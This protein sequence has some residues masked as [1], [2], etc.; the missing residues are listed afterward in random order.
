[1]KKLMVFFL[2]S[3]LLIEPVLASEFVPSSPKL[4]K[5]ELLYEKYEYLDSKYDKI[6]YIKNVGFIVAKKI[7]DASGDFDYYYGLY[8]TN[9][10]KVVELNKGVFI[11][12]LAD[13]DYDYI[14]TIAFPFL[15]NRKRFQRF[16]VVEK[17][18]KYALYDGRTGELSE[19]VF[20]NIY[21]TFGRTPIVCINGKEYKL[22]PVKNAF[23]SSIYFVRDAGLSII[24]FPIFVG[25][26]ILFAIAMGVADM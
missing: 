8:D 1:M 13:K 6:D 9:L 5:K 16:L 15:Q 19:I 12:P 23:N 14:P 2:S 22:Q 18:K 20:D 11:K 25:G 4:S 17:D 3:V 24:S 10:D 26:A 21:P 7:S